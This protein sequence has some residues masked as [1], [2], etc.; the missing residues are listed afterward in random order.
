MNI[1]SHYIVTSTFYLPS[2]NDVQTKRSFTHVLLFSN[3][4]LERA[5]YTVSHNILFIGFPF[6]Q[7]MSYE[8]FPSFVAD[9]TE[10]QITAISCPT[11]ITTALSAA[12][13]IQLVRKSRLKGFCRVF[14]FCV[15]IE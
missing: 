6:V 9:N 12:G 1:K 15:Q 10:Q 4:W 11:T 5:E 3:N 13:T 8:L 7:S 2:D 14:I